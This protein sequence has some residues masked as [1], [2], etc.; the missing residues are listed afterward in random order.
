MNGVNMVQ[1]RREE[2]EKSGNDGSIF[3]DRRRCTTDM[4]LASTSPDALARAG[5]DQLDAESGSC[6]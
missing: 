3:P 1:L 6:G 2:K 4:A 5:L